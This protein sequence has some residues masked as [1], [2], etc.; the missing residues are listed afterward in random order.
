M[1]DTPKGVL[2]VKESDMNSPS[3]FPGIPYD[4]L[5]RHI[6]LYAPIHTLQE[7]LLYSGINELVG[8]E[9]GGESS[10]E[11]EVE[12]LSDTPTALRQSAI[13]EELPPRPL[14]G[15]N[16]ISGEKWKENIGR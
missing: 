12:G 8:E 10:V 6:V 7:G 11:K 4:F 5:H 15:K 16:Q 2:Q 9:E 13:T 3:L 14:P 1:G